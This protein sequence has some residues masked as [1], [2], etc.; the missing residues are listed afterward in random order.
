MERKYQAFPTI[1]FDM[2]MGGGGGKQ[3]KRNFHLKKIKKCHK[4]E[5]GYT[6][7]ET[8]KKI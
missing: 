6:F 2:E 1:N 8:V 5:L 4:G 3:V 7:I